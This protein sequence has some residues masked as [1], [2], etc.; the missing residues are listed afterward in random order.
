MKDILIKAL[1]LGG[2]DIFVVPGSPVMTKVNGHM[3][4]LGREK[5]RPERCRELIWQTYEM[6]AERDVGQL[7][8]NGENRFGWHRMSFSLMS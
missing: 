4:N 6:A 7:L 1:E 2:S 5:L 8:E 3:I